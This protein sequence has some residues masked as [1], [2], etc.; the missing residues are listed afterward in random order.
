M[1]TRPVHSTDAMGWRHQDACMQPGQCMSQ[2]PWDS[3]IVT[4]GLFLQEVGPFGVGWV[5]RKHSWVEKASL[6]FLDNPVGTGFS[7]VEE[8]ANFTHSNAEIAADLMT[9]LQGFLKDKPQVRLSKTWACSLAN[10][11]CMIGMSKCGLRW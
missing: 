1:S 5:V 6:L 10:N 7:Y 4:H 8:G 9:F 2:T 11:D 3:G